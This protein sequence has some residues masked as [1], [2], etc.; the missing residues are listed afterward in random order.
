MPS[1]GL[2]PRAEQ[3]PQFIHARP[4]GI[5]RPNLFHEPSDLILR[6]THLAEHLDQSGTG[7][8]IARKELH[9]GKRANQAVDDFGIHYAQICARSPKKIKY[10]RYYRI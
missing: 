9:Q 5:L 8:R 10:G 2:E 4:F 1:C 7:V 6:F 3:P